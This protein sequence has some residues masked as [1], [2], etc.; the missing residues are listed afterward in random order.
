MNCDVAN[1]AAPH[2]ARAC[3]VD[4]ACHSSFLALQTATSHK[5]NHSASLRVPICLKH[6]SPLAFPSINHGCDNSIPR[7]CSQAPIPAFNIVILRPQ[8]CGSN[9]FIT[10]CKID[11]AVVTTTP[12]RNTSLAAQRRHEGPQ[13]SSGGL[14]DTQD[15]GRT[16]HAFSKHST[17]CRWAITSI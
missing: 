10:A 16:G 7:P 14:Q 12:S 4:R 3:R 11:V 5:S 9:K 2:F 13:V 1:K 6:K 17:S 15:I 8:T